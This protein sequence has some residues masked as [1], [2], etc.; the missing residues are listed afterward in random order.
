MVTIPSWRKIRRQC[1]RL[2]LS[3][4]TVLHLDLEF[5]ASNS[6]LERTSARRLIRLLARPSRGPKPLS[7]R[8]WTTEPKVNAMNCYYHAGSDA[9]ALC[10]NCN[11]GVCHDC[12]AEVTNGT[13]CVNRC[14]AEV[15][16]INEVLQRNK[17]GYQKAS[18]AYARNAV[19]Y[20]IMGL[21]MLAIGALTM[22]GGVVMLALGGAMLLGS[23]LSYGTSRKMARPGP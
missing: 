7:K 17:T 8:R 2:P 23:L 21:I 15:L 13:A 6:M 3:R 5:A 22:P 10:K 4:E 19:L 9:V 12:A 1:P 11:R 16:A 20:L 14:E 18:G